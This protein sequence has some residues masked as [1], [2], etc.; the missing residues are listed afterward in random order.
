MDENELRGLKYL[1]N[2]G[3]RVMVTEEKYTDPN[4][5]N[6]K[7]ETRQF[8]STE[9]EAKAYCAKNQSPNTIHKITKDRATVDYY[10]SMPIHD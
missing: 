9:D 6:K 4:H 8:F 5:V 2:Q 3:L 7:E 10:L 1:G